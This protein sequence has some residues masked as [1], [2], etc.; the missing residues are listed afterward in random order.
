MATGKPIVESEYY[1]V[2]NRGNNKQP[3][4]KNDNDRYRLLFLLMYFQSPKVSFTNLSA[5]VKLFRKNFL[6]ERYVPEIEA[7]KTID[8]VSFILMPNHFHLILYERKQG[9]IAKYMQRVQNSYTKYFNTRH[10]Q[11]GH[12][13]QGTYKAVHLKTNEQLIYLSAYIHRN[14]RE[15]KGW[16]NSEHKYPWSSY[17]DYLG[18]NRWGKLINPSIIL[19]QFNSAKEYR[20]AVKSSEAKESPEK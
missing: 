10:E 13:F 2:L 4:F 5:T 3:I 11:S 1:H 12:L 16:R 7:T 20:E 9:G 19:E 14:S 6:L 15:I 8:L 17:Q 18:A